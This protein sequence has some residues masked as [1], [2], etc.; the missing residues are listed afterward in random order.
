MPSGNDWIPSREQDLINLIA[1]WQ[2]K[3]A[4][5]SLQTAYGWVASECTATVTAL[6]TFVTARTAYQTTPTHSNLLVKD[7]AKK[8]AI[9]A[10]RK[11]AA[12]RIRN[13]SKMNEGQKDELGVLTR[14]PKPTPIPVPED[15][16]ACR[17]KISAYR[18]GEVK[19][20]YEGA[21]PYGVVTVDVAHGVLAAPP[22]FAEDLPHRDSFTRT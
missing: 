15:G 13:N 7:S 18:P 17:T 5:A 1:V 16:P 11:F 12:E 3:L 9:A 4:N 19:V 22:E 10:M 6:T 20:Y 8:A 14:D 21:K 2:V